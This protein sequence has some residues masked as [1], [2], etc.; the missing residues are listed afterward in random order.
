MFMS[1]QAE[2]QQKF[3]ERLA[4]LTYAQT[5]HNEAVKMSK[6]RLYLQSL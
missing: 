3:G 2:E 4:Y 6:V 5:K 1:N